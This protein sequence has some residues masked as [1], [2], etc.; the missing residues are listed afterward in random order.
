MIVDSYIRDEV[1]NRREITSSMV[2]RAE[3]K[4]YLES[5]EYKYTQYLMQAARPAINYG[6]YPYSYMAGRFGLF[7]GYF[8]Q[9]C[10]CPYCGK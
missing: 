10:R 2:G 1:G 4:R 9:P 6:G 7:G 8:Q 5:P 3:R